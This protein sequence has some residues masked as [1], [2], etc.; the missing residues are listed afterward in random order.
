MEN[1]LQGDDN[2][3]Q[4]LLPVKL[5]LSCYSCSGCLLQIP[6]CS[7]EWGQAT[8][9]SSS[10]IWGVWSVS[11]TPELF[12]ESFAG[13]PAG[14]LWANT[15]PRRGSPSRLPSPAS[16]ADHGPA[17]LLGRSLSAGTWRDTGSV[18]ACAFRPSPDNLH[19]LCGS[20]SCVWCLLRREH[21]VWTGPAQQR[22]TGLVK[23]PASA[24]TALL[25]WSF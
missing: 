2:P 25:S 3:L 7:W 4:L 8:R 11:W 20:W 21:S 1:C 17:R 16:P 24:G 12:R 13:S 18:S 14:A 5:T 22:Q 23:N 19:D 15:C 9:L 6:N 10:A